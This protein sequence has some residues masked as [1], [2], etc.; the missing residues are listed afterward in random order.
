VRRRALVLVGVLAVALLLGSACAIV[1]GVQDDTHAASAVICSCEPWQSSLPDCQQDVEGRLTGAT[2]D[3]R[4][5]WLQ[6]FGNQCM[7][8]CP[9][10]FTCFY[11]AP[12]CLST[13][14]TCKQ[15]LECC[16]YFPNNDAT[17]CQVPGVCK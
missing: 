16:S 12:V 6:D 17:A 7:M 2:P 5:K 15:P 10:M 14:S 8:S 1:L 9:D 11:E 3:V 13:G 4:S